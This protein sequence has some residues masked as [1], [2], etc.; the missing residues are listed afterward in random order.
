MLRLSA[1]DSILDLNPDVGG[2]ICRF[3]HKGADVMRPTPAGEK[4]VLQTASFPLVPFCN[5]IRNGTF[6]VEGHRVQMPGNLGD[7]PHTLH[8]H[9][10][11][12]PWQVSDHSGSRAVLT[13]RHVPDS[14]PWEY[15]ATLVYDL[16]PGAFRATLSVHNLAPGTMPA[17]LG[18]HPYFN[19]SNQTRLK[20]AVDGVWLSDDEHLPRNWH[21]GVL[22]KDWSHGDMVRHDVLIDNCYTGFHGKAEIYEGERLTHTLRASPDCKWLHI[23]VPPGESFFCAEPV[24]HMPDPFNQPNSGL[25]CLKSGASDTVWMDLQV[26]S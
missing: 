13:Y 3:I 20:A 9:G 19:L 14:W 8:G 7:S 11:L 10:W 21:A 16:R 26:H 17:G 4:Q 2:A 24:D 22:R 5:R 25:K 12:K 18:F 6:V 23:Y 1:G 15:E